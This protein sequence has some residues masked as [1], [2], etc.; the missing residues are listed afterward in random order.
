MDEPLPDAYGPARDFVTLMMEKACSPF[1]R[2]VK[3]LEEEALGYINSHLNSRNYTKN[4]VIR[5]FREAW[6]HV[7]NQNSTIQKLKEENERLSAKLIAD[8]EEVISLHKE[9]KNIRDQE[10]EGLKTVVET[11]VDVTMK[12]SYSEAAST[13]S[14]LPSATT[15]DSRGMRK[16]IQDATEADVRACNVVL[17]GLSETVS[18]D[19]KV[20]VSKVLDTVGEK[21]HFEAERIGTRR[22]G[23]TRPVLVK[24]RSGIVAAGIRKKAG[25]LK[26]SDTFKN[27]YICPDRTLMQRKEHRE[28]VA[29]LRRRCKD[30]PDRR[31]VIRDGVVVSMDKNQDKG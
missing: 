24:F 6:I 18:E 7:V 10:I 16:A 19:I 1:S 22:E 31:H 12:K 21:P 3:P 30:A 20:D 9:I 23:A 2:T 11:A 5:K 27:V 17:F 4:C 25:I 14:V 26:K 8:H 15:L 28:C 29:E 13:A